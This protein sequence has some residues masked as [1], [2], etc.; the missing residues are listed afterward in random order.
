MRLKRIL[1]LE[2]APSETT[3]VMA[4]CVIM[5]RLADTSE[6]DALVSLFDSRVTVRC[7]GRDAPRQLERTELVDAWFEAAATV[8]RTRH[9]VRNIKVEVQN[10]T[11][12][13]SAEFRAEYLLD[14]P[15]S[16]DSGWVADG[17]FDW[18][19]ERQGNR[20]R[21]SSLTITIVGEAGHRPSA[22][23]DWPRELVTRT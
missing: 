16:N 13:C 10:Q 7:A 20:W 9:H 2:S 5:T 8:L 18:T 22:F 12:T 15:S 17:R 21:I 4:V 3:D 14:E 11:A 6:R 19:L 1:G 23:R